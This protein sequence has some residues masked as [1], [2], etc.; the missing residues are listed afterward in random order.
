MPATPRLVGSVAP[1]AERRALLRCVALL[2]LAALGDAETSASV[3]RLCA[4]AKR[5]LPLALLSRLS[6]PAGALHAA[7]VCVHPAF[8]SVARRALD[9]SKVRVA[10]VAGRFPSGRAPLRAKVEEIRRALDAG[11]QEI[12][13]VITAGF[14]RRG[15][16]RA[17]EDEVAAFREACGR[18]TLKVILRT[19]VLGGP[20]NV[21]RASGLAI[22]AGADFIK[23]S[24]GRERVNATLPVGRVMAE[25]IRRHR[26]RRVG[27]KPSGG[28]RTAPQALDWLELARA[29]LGEAWT[30]PSLLRIG[31]SAVLA[32][33]EARLWELA[34]LRR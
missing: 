24:T 30:R 13:A 33:I 26:S 6:R 15:H 2:D 8:V 10:A 7:A 19:G 14:A 5:P 11:A 18:R 34:P 22:R 3:R 31:A 21:R 4:R 25:A 12:D 23:T 20:P 28:I 17:L 16:W 1:D 32:D 27:L 9:G 29:E